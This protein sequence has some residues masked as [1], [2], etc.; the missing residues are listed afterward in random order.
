MPV[1]LEAPAP[2]SVASPQEVY[3]TEKQKVVLSQISPTGYLCTMPV[4]V[5]GRVDFTDLPSGSTIE[6]LLK[7]G[8]QPVIFKVK[9]GVK[10]S[11]LD[12]LRVH[13]KIE[14][15]TESGGY[16]R[17]KDYAYLS[18]PNFESING[19]YDFN[20]TKFQGTEL[21]TRLKID[22]ETY[23]RCAEYPS[24]RKIFCRHLALA[25]LKLRTEKRHGSW[26]N[27]YQTYF[28]KNALPS[29]F[30]D[31]QKYEDAVI[32]VHVSSQYQYVAYKN[33]LGSVLHVMFKNIL[34]HMEANKTLEAMFYVTLNGPDPKISGHSCALV[35][36]CESD[37]DNNPT[38]KIKLYDPN[39]TYNHM[40]FSTLDI[41]KIKKL[42]FEDIFMHHAS[43]EEYD[44]LNFFEL[45]SGWSEGISQ[46]QATWHESK[47]VHVHEYSPDSDTLVLVR[48]SYLKNNLDLWDFK[49]VAEE[50]I[51]YGD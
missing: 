46:L 16:A 12:P 7:Q 1:S 21:K 37:K 44:S 3:R 45:N 17:A 14:V 51:P 24:E 22:E 11:V 32:D 39:L 30:N 41:A 38:F 5:S 50:E 36:K 9:D 6:M 8:Q 10:V 25:A 23:E 15:K 49:K 28:H 13:T 20:D 42:Q 29:V 18:R 19:D 26:T 2:V 4:T 27:N 47:V 31:I 34:K 35:V 40:T 33:E 48:K 43:Y